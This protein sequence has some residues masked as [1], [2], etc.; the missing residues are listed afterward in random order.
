MDSAGT[1]NSILKTW[2][3][4]LVLLENVTY[5]VFIHLILIVFSFFFQAIQK[6]AQQSKEIEHLRNNPYLHT[7]NRSSDLD[8]LPLQYIKQLQAQLIIDLDTLEKV[9]KNALLIK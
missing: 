2:H 6:L 8:A 4:R 9:S 3:L 7:L 1:K 5:S